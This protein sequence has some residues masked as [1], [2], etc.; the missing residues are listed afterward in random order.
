M[1][2]FYD[3]FLDT[4][5][6]CQYVPNVFVSVDEDKIIR[7]SQI[8]IDKY[9][10][11]FV[12]ES[13]ISNT[14]EE[15]K[16]CIKNVVANYASYEMEKIGNNFLSNLGNTY[17]ETTNVKSNFGEKQDALEAY[18]NNGDLYLDKLLS[19]ANEEDINITGKIKSKFFPSVQIFEE[20][21]YISNSFRT[22]IAL[23]PAIRQIEIIKIIPLI[24]GLGPLPDEL[25]YAIRGY[26]ANSAVLK[27]LSQLRVNES[28]LVYSSFLSHL[29]QKNNR[30]ELVD[31][32]KSINED[33]ETYS[34]LLECEL[35]KL[36]P[37]EDSS[38]E[39]SSENTGIWI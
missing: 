5:D 29:S 35:N 14:D 33:I 23:Q 2:K 10:L 30:I 21:K 17:N 9:L 22:F 6:F 19:L 20:F 4:N 37:G 16:E 24:N 32:Q 27:G 36:F 25:L 18:A 11:K 28:G 12:K 39:N 34:A 7:N 13:I 3:I 1:I 38:Y 31:I 26:I 8:A 15:I